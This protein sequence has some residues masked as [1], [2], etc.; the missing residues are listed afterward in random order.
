[1]EP[2]A[3]T[4]SLRAQIA[5]LQ[6]ELDSLRARYDTL[7]EAKNRAAEHYK[8]DFKKW[9]DFKRWLFRDAE[10]DDHVKS[11]LKSSELVAYTR[12][13]TLGKRKQFEDFGSNVDAAEDDN[14][15]RDHKQESIKVDL[16]H[17]P[18]VLSRLQRRKSYH[19]ESSNKVLSPTPG[20]RDPFLVQQS[21]NH[22]DQPSVL[23]HENGSL[24]SSFRRAVD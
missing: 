11:I 14:E 15:T 10:T 2:P 3:D 5:H 6:A 8:A 18:P 7:L 17:S 19:G 21:T 20:N 1:M 16:S 22:N 24:P 13:T 12:D 23:N 9:R 4:A